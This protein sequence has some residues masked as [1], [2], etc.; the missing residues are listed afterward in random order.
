MLRKTIWRSIRGL[1]TILIKTSGDELIKARTGLH[2]RSDGKCTTRQWLR[3]YNPRV[4]AARILQ[5]PR[6]R[7]QFTKRCSKERSHGEK[8]PSMLISI[9]QITIMDCKSIIYKYNSKI[10]NHH[11]PFKAHIYSKSIHCILIIYKISMK[12]SYKITFYIISPLLMNR[13]WYDLNV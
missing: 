1:W 12:L 9:K 6:M 10:S 7:V 13:L 5:A 4:S 11:P 2:K 3:R 8:K